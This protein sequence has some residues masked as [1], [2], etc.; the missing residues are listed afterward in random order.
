MRLTIAAF[1]AALTVAPVIDAKT[2][3][4]AS[5]GD[6]LT[7]DPHAQNEGLNNTA[8]SYIYEPLVTYNEKFEV[9][10]ALATD[11]KQETPLIW[12]FNLRQGVKFHD[13]SALT[14]SDVVFSIDRAMQPTSNFRQYTVG[15]Q[16][17]HAVDDNTVI[18]YTTVPNPVLLRQLTELRIVSK[19][20]AEKNK[21]VAPQNFVQKEETYAARNA[22]GTGPFILK[23]R[24]VDIKTVFATNPN[25][26]GAKTKKG[27]V[28]EVVYT[29]IKSDSTRTA[30]LLS[31]EID[32]LLD[33]V[34]QD[35][36]RLKQTPSIKVVEGAENRT[37]FIGM[38]Q[39][40]DEL[41]YSD[42]KGKNP[43][44]DL[45][46]RQALYHAI[47]IEAIKKAVMRGLVGSY[48]RDHP[49][50][51]QRLG[52]GSARAL[53]LRREESEGAANGSGLSERLCGH[54]RLPEQPLHQRRGSLQSAG[55]DVGQARAEG[56]IERNAAR[57]VLSEDS[58]TRHVALSAWLGRADV[59]RAVLVAI[60]ADDGRQRWRRQLQSGSR[61]QRRV[62][63][64][65]RIDQRRS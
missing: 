44:K 22:N 59:R 6:I 33:P 11:W 23:S 51:G 58:E 28:T 3:R 43:F 62:R 15:V 57:D 55:R 34:P 53:A 16:R 48:W 31:G 45:R 4:W 13:G 12:R 64:V 10:P 63:Q 20:W 7:M 1:A 38:D 9:V 60:A 54:A 36:A 21:V 25:W 65:G 18:I 8:N 46:V 30:A 50:R 29:P 24:E 14:A 47:D 27:N 37:I 49:A 2:L 5:Q 35:I 19:G 17:A 26:W 52:T 56:V 41:Q 61:E 32:F 40:R 39:F 42:V